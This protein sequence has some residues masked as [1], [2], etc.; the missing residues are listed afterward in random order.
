MLLGELLVVR[1]VAAKEPVVSIKWV[2]VVSE[3]TGVLVTAIVAK[4]AVQCSGV[5]VAISLW[6]IRC[7][8]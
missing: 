8:K 3:W 7:L 2:V 1:V 4:F 5:K 6:Y